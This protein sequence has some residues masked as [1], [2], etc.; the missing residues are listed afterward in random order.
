MLQ[1]AE[2]QLVIPLPG[3]GMVR[4]GGDEV[5][6]RDQRVALDGGIVVDRPTV[7]TEFTGVIVDTS[8]NPASC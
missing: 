4:L 5:A 7:L 3:A 2:L 8:G 6:P 1:G